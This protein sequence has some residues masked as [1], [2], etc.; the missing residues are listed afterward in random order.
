MPNFVFVNL[1]FFFLLKEGSLNYR[2]F[3]LTNFEG[4]F[5]YLGPQ[6]VH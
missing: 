2:S 6:K 3:M 4:A 1:Q 5:D